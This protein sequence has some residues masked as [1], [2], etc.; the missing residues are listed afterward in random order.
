RFFAT[1]KGGL[2]YLLPIVMLVYELV[3]LRHSPE[4]AAF[5]AIL[6]LIAIIFVRGIR[7]GLK[8]KAVG[9]GKGFF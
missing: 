3:V 1:L 9:L 5:N 7:N 4:K 8:D 6:V 2:H